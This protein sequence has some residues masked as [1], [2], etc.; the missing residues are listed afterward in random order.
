FL[1]TRQRTRE[2]LM[3]LLMTAAWLAGVAVA[4]SAMLAAP[5]E[6]TPRPG[7]MTEARVWVQNRGAAEAL[8]VEL[9]GSTLA[10]PLRGRVVNRAAASGAR[11]ER[12]R[13][14]GA[15][16]AARAADGVGMGV[17]CGVAQGDRGCLPCVGASRRGRVGS[18]WRGIRDL[19]RRHADDEAAPLTRWRPGRS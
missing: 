5:G 6:Q 2:D 8:P 14:I 16:R 18:D 11:D 17:P 9:A 10:Q 7:Q 1:R 13:R 4:G 15:D 3:K 19:R 12:R